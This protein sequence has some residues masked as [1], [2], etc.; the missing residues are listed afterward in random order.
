[1][2]PHT[3]RLLCVHPQPL[4]LRGELILVN[5][6]GALC[7][8]A[9]RALAHGWRSVGRDASVVQTG[10]CHDAGMHS[11]I[12]R[13]VVA[14]GRGPTT[15]IAHATKLRGFNT[16]ALVWS[17]AHGGLVGACVVC[18]SRMHAVGLRRFMRS[19]VAS[20]Y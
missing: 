3:A 20:H 8:H 18:V 7:L 2:S 9:R 1:M 19:I 15:G 10:R 12:P 4:M 16:L 17:I 11:H 13:R 6:I 5:Q 14:P